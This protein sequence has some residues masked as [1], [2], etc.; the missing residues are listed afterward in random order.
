MGETEVTQELWYAVMGRNSSSVVGD[1]YPVDNIQ[2]GSCI[3]FANQLSEMT[4]QNFRLPTEAEWEFAARGGNKTLGYTYSG[5]DDCNEVAWYSANSGRT[6]HEVAT[7]QPN[8]LGLYDMS[9]NVQEWCSDLAGAYPNEA[10]IDPTGPAKGS[11]LVVRGGSYAGLS[12]QTSVTARNTDY[13]STNY[14]P[15]LG[16][17]LALTPSE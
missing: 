16:F 5:S 1:K 10:V 11:K 9:G 3:T 17:R 15:G 7:K 2:K 13:N 14:Y 8:E 12:I 6:I 4:G